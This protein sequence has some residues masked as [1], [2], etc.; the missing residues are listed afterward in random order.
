MGPNDDHP[1]TRKGSWRDTT[2]VAAQE[3]C[4]RILGSIAELAFSILSRGEALVPVAMGI[5]LDGNI[6]I[7][8][9]QFASTSL[10]A[11][12]ELFAVLKG[13]AYAVADCRD[14]VGC[15]PSRWARRTAG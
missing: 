13:S 15:A 7:V 12:T 11:R 1:A 4:D 8:P 14:R 6:S 2:S 5:R 10:S 3:D 9:P